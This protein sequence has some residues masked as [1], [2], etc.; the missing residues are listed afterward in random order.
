MNITKKSRD[1]I[2]ANSEISFLNFSFD[3]VNTFYVLPYFILSYF[4]P[5][6][7]IFSR[8]TKWLFSERFFLVL[9]RHIHSKNK[10]LFFSDFFGQI[11]QLNIFDTFKTLK[12]HKINQATAH[13]KRESNHT[14][15]MSKCWSLDTL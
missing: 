15:K 10:Q 9:E 8:D 2:S 5:G 12:K 14:K 11:F 7:I 6:I 4:F 1:S 3:K 13:S